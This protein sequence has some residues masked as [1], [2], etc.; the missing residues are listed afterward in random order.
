MTHPTEMLS[1]LLDGELEGADRA[2]VEAHVAEC[3]ACAAELREI[4]ALDALA[5]QLPPV[6]APAGYHEG[7]PGRLRPRLRR[8]GSAPRLVRPWLWA[9]AAGIAV[10][11]VAPIVLRQPPRDV[12]PA[13]PEAAAA[14]GDRALASPPQATPP[15]ARAA[16]LQDTAVAR[17]RAA[18]QAAAPAPR[19]DDFA[20]PPP[21]AAPAE[22]RAES[23]RAARSDGGVAG[24]V[25]AGAGAPAA[26]AEQEAV[27]APRQGKE[28]GVGFARSKANADELK[29]AAEPGPARRLRERW[30]RVVEAQPEGP[31]ADD[32]RVRMIEAGIE[33]YRLG[34]DEADRLQ[35][36]R[37][38]EAY[39]A[40]ADAAQAGHVRE[41][42][43]RLREERR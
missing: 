12:P 25:L 18:N 17:P 29:K 5:R 33:A 7:L 30:R 28:E 34:G 24:G 36:L 31:R 1:A 8:R 4:G 41:I 13:A 2:R 38:A 35:A 40:R 20:A 14:P 39:L 23:D 32:A 37:D 10:A 22:K 11:V 9:V 6:D 26:T 27:E 43:R 42:V 16:T 19:R 21:A 3:A 15:A